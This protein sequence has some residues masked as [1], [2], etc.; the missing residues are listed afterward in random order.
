MTKNKVFDFLNE[1]H[2]GG[3][4]G[5]YWTD[6]TKKSTWFQAGQP[7]KIPNGHANW[8]FGIHATN[9]GGRVGER[10]KNATVSAVNCLYADFDAKDY[11]DKTA[12][13]NHVISLP[14]M[15]SVLID[16]GGGYHAYWLLKDTLI[17][18]SEADRQSAANIQA[19][20]AAFVGGDPGAKDLA[21][22]LR[23]PGTR[24]LKYENKPAVKFVGQWVSLDLK[25]DLNYLDELSQPKTKT[26]PKQT[27]KRQPGSPKD[28]GTHWLE[29]ARLRATVG[30]RNNTGFWLAC[31]L[32]DS[33]LA[34]GEA[35]PIMRAYAASVPG[36]N[37]SEA[38]AL[39]SLKSAYAQTARPPATGQGLGTEIRADIDLAKAPEN[40][41]TIRILLSQ[42]RDH[43]GHANCVLSLYPDKFSFCREFGWMFYNGQ[44]WQQQNAEERVERAIVE[45]LKAR[46]LLAVEKEV[47]AIVKVTRATA[48]NVKGTKDLLK[49]LVLVKPSDFDKAPDLLN[50][51]NGV[52]DL[53]SGE[54]IPHDHAQMFT[55]SLPIDYDPAASS[56]TWETFLHAVCGRDLTEYLQMALGY[57]LTG[58]TWEEI[59]FY[60]FGPT[61]SGKGTFTE[62]VLNMFGHGPIATESDFETF[63][64]SRTGDTQNFDLAPL[65]PCRFVAASESNKH[66]PLNPAKIKQ[67]TGGNF[68][69]CAFKHRTHFTYR[70]QFKIWLSSNHPVNVDVDDD[71][72]WARV[73]V[74]HF[75]NSYLGK[76]DKTLKRRLSQP[77]N[78]RGVLLWA[79]EG[80]R[81]WY[82]DKNGLPYPETI[83]QATDTQ[84]E[85]QDFIQQFIDEECSVADD[86]YISI[87][88]LHAA[89]KNWCNDNGVPPK[90]MKAFSLA[91]VGKGF[92][93]TRKRLQGR[94]VRGIA[95]LTIGP[96]ADD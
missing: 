2:K 84:R 35:G 11:G 29:Q 59:L 7:A 86:K 48:A 46:R 36:D 10:S 60:I 32:R 79:A 23:I 16:T 8:Y 63:T 53:R 75:P 92:K 41:E 37:Y 90:H 43:E 62:T 5:F 17:L 77:E 70:P 78:L 21:R 1:L 9:E 26:T 50:C 76:E 88:N 82:A 3:K 81:R 68:I 49:S 66:N 67:L 27:A 71:A 24:N 13:L 25:Y 54:L 64:A 93:R 96:A 52:L 89:Y 15:P 12:T 42:S 95:G 28:A 65:K 40:D 72:A 87:G 94:Q 51:K 14:V 30:T 47:E 6:K 91:L 31:Q 18:A 20:W 73:R 4:W 56:K 44:H 85:A 80:A 39:A 19:N 69:R 38:E 61:R 22:V 55:Y 74:I 33:G 58:H 83:Q 45:T 34:I 57:S